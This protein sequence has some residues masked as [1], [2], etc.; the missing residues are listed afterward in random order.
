MVRTFAELYAFELHAS[1][2]GRGFDAFGLFTTASDNDHDSNGSTV[3]MKFTRAGLPINSPVPVN[4]SSCPTIIFHVCA[5]A[6]T[7]LGRWRMV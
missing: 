7:P 5:T 4:Y 3:L 2:K 1:P 6:L